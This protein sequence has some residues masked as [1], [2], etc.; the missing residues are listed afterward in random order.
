[1]EETEASSG[2]IFPVE[3]DQ[4]VDEEK[5]MENV[6]ADEVKESVDEENLEDNKV[7]TSTT[8]GIEYSF[9]TF[10]NWFMPSCMD[11]WTTED[12]VTGEVSGADFETIIA[13]GARS[14]LFLLDVKRSNSQ[15]QSARVGRLLVDE[16]SAPAPNY[17]IH[18]RDLVNVFN[19]SASKKF[20][21]VFRSTNAYVTTVVFEKTK[22][23]VGRNHRSLTGLKDNHG[24]LFCFLLF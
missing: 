4:T 17:G 23:F 5:N 13:Y 12:N 3:D 14:Y 6:E 18:Y 9:G 2:D 22:D 20:T 16:A 11:L 7:V 15:P 1:M 21:D 19:H 10:F 8:T 24:K